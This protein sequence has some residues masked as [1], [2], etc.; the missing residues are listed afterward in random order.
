[1]AALVTWLRRFGFWLGPIVL[2]GSLLL[3]VLLVLG[4]VVFYPLF[5]PA[6]LLLVVPAGGLWLGWSLLTGSTQP[7][8]AKLLAPVLSPVLGWL[9]WVLVIAPAFSARD[10]LI[11]LVPVGFRGDVVLLQDPKADK[12]LPP[13]Y[14]GYITLYVPPN[15]LL[16]TSDN[17]RSDWLTTAQYYAVNAAIQRLGELPQLDGRDANQ[18]GQLPENNPIGVFL[19]GPGRKRAKAGLAGSHPALPASYLDQTTEHLSFTVAP[20]LV[21]PTWRAP[22]PTQHLRPETTNP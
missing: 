19:T 16:T 18:N 9:L 10:R 3:A 20:A 14:D 21:V 17:L 11:F 15:G 12:P 8:W 2:V 13:A 4:G 7:L 22:L 1:M 6:L 5:I